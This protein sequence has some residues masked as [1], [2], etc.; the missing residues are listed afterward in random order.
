MP[1]A[2]A[3]RGRKSA[4]PRPRVDAA[5]DP[6]RRPEEIKSSKSRL[7]AVKAA[8]WSSKA[9]AALR[10]KRAACS[11]AWIARPRASLTWE[12]H[13]QKQNENMRKASATKNL[14]TNA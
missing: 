8:P 4:R 6:Q 1:Q 12:R 7:Q 2:R 10:L 5:G 11:V 9:T 13:R 14:H 3:A